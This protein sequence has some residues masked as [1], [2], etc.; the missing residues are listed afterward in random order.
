MLPAW[1]WPWIGPTRRAMTGAAG[2]LLVL[3]SAA[4]ALAVAFLVGQHY[5]LGVRTGWYLFLQSAY[6]TWRPLTTILAVVTLL[7]AWRLVGTATAR[8]LPDSGD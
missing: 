5:E 6:G 7:A 3:L 4:P 8:L 2:T 1:L